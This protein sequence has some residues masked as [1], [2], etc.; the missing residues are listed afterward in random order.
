[1]HSNCIIVG[2]ISRS[3][4]CDIQ[5]NEY[6]LVPNSLAGMFAESR[7]VDTGKIKKSLDA[8]SSAIL[9]EYENFLIRNELAFYA[10]SLKECSHFPPVSTEWDFPAHI[11]N[12]IIDVSDAYELDLASVLASLKNL[13]CRYIQFR[14]YEKVRMP[15]LKKMVGLVNNSHVISI[16][17][18][19]PSEGLEVSELISLVENNRKIN[20]FIL[21]NYAY[22]GVL[23]DEGGFG[24]GKILTVSERLESEMHCGIIHPNYF[25][26]NIETYTEAQH[27]NTCLNRKISIDRNGFI[28]N[29]PS[30]KQ[31]FGHL[32]DTKLE[33]VAGNEA[34][35]QYWHIRKDEI[36]KCR[37]CEF[38]YICTDCRA[39]TENPGDL[40]AAPLKC[41]YDPYSCEWEEW[42]SNPLKKKAM[43]TYSDSPT[44][45]YSE[46]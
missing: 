28:K 37:D 26:V 36:T 8:H 42:S 20:H 39:Y 1:L 19:A 21:H 2:G 34:F 4:I 5:R 40:H 22:D 31:H 16:D 23:Y 12:M 44:L 38:R 33:D 25:S 24:V 30:M 41:G 46:A 6:H 17:I 27:F 7:F 11:S 29:C 15:Q 45:Q 14:F 10:G 9:D 32:S 18:L 3:T 35:R 13:N 43:E